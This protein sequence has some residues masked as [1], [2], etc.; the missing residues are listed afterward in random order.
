MGLAHQSL[1]SPCR[2]FFY[3]S[4]HFS[5]CSSFR[6]TPGNTGALLAFR[7]NQG[8]SSSAL[9]FA[10]LSPRPS[11]WGYPWI[12]LGLDPGRSHLF[13]CLFVFKLAIPGPNPRASQVVLVV[14]NCSA[15]AGDIRDM[16]LIPGLGRSPGGGPGNPLQYSFLENSLNRGAWWVTVHKS[17]K[18]RYEWTD[19]AC[20]QGPNPSTAKPARLE[21]PEWSLDIEKT[22]LKHNLFLSLGQS[23]LRIECKVD[24]TGLF[25]SERPKL[26]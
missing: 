5:L 13:V 11:S 9:C 17:Q 7:V 21:F 15:H 2:S 26:N 20:T 3:F 10:I 24:V 1:V 8:R 23:L 19:L 16:D 12:L 6:M 14:K 18:V 4:H 25:I 22:R